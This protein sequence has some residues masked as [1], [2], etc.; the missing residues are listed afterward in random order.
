MASN[1][2]FDAQPY[3]WRDMGEHTLDKVRR[4]NTIVIERTVNG[5]VTISRGT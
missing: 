5:S 4:D 3:Q 1:W 2:L